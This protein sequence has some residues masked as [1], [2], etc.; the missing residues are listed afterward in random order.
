MKFMRNLPENIQDRLRSL[1]AKF[2]KEITFYDYDEVWKKAIEIKSD[3]HVITY[4][5]AYVD[6]DNGSRY[7]KRATIFRGATPE[8][9]EKW[10]HLLIEGMPKRNLQENFIFLNA[11]NEWSEGAYLEPDER[12]GYDYL[13]AVRRAQLSSNREI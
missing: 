13:E 9:F 7:K 5:G 10:L 11:W 8:K 4:P 2:F 12:F 6:W 1:R 3:Q